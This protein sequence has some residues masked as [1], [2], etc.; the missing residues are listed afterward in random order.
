MPFTA[1][2]DEFNKAITTLD[3]KRL[4]KFVC[5]FWIEASYKSGGKAIKYRSESHVGNGSYLKV[6]DFCELSP[7]KMEYKDILKLFKENKIRIPEFL[8][9]EWADKE[10][11]RCRKMKEVAGMF[12]A[13][14]IGCAA[15]KTIMS[16]RKN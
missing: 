15:I 12:I 13:C 1:S 2:V 16:L 5:D 3:Y 6:E 10:R 4:D 11:E 14:G 9:K 7:W 8:T